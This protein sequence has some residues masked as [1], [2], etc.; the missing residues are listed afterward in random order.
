MARDLRDGLR[1]GTSADQA[2]SKHSSSLK[3]RGTIF[4]VSDDAKRF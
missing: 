1:Q 2:L 3:A 4:T